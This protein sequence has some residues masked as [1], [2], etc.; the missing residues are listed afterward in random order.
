MPYKV[1]FTDVTIHP[2]PITVFD[3]T[4]STDTS[5]TFPGRNVTGYGQI[6]AENFLHLLENFASG[7]EPV[8]PVEGQLWYDSTNGTLMIWDNTAWK[9]ASNIQ[10]SPTEPSVQTSKIGELWVDTTNQ[11]LR[12]F[13]GTRWILVGPS[14]SSI[15]GLRYGPAVETIPDSDNISR[16]I[17]V[18]YLKDVPVVIIS[19][20]SFTPKVSISG[21]EFVKA[22]INIATPKDTT[23]KTTFATIFSGGY[24]PKLFGTAS[25]ADALNVVD[26]SGATTTVAAGKFLR[27]DIVNS[28]DYGFNVKNNNGIIIG[29]DGTFKLEASPTAAKIYNSSAGSSVDIQTN[30]NG[31][32]TTVLTVIDN[33]VGINKSSPD[34]EFDVDGN[35]GLNGSLIVSSTTESTNL[36][37][38]SIRTAGGIAVSKN[39]LVGSGIDVTGITQTNDVQPKLT[40]T[41]DSGT[42]LKRWKTVRAKT[43]EAD[44]IKGNLTGSIDGN[45]N[46]ANSLKTVT[47]F[48]LQ[49][50]V[51]S[52]TISFDGQVGSSAKVFATS[53]TA[54]IIKSKDEPFPN[55]SK[56]TD[57]I[58]TYRASEESGTSSGLLKQTR[59]TFIGDLGVP[60]G[61][62]LPYAGANAPYGY[63]LC[64]GSEVEKV[65]F[66]E[67]FDIIGTTYN[68]S[69]ALIGVG[70]YRLPDMRG[71]FALGRD[72]MDNGLTVP[73]VLNTYV[74][75]GGGT[76]SRVPD[77]NAQQLGKSAGGSS[78]SLT[79]TN[80]PDH[81]HS[82]QNSG[83]QYA[84]V[85]VDTAINPP[86]TTGLGPTAPGQ[87]QYLTT[88][89]PVKKPDPT[90]SLGTPVGIMNPYLTINYIIRSGPPAFTTTV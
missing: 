37:N 39:I 59:D 26:A 52:D 46:T 66:P 35:I 7:N 42:S 5:L 13:S 51:I 24:L 80:L 45:A 14:E 22:G 54:N 31:R 73:N 20:D 34:Y 29:V 89:G 33:K 63:L 48:K 79:L 49:G 56:K 81:E 71:R 47:T 3:N 90:F 36:N 69:A 87:A 1:N 15:D 40:D 85:R 23:E 57:Y 53:L 44:T 11:Q 8:N 72:N 67:L 43:I 77:T 76:A 84:A 68:G 25:D 65:K 28:T 27:S 64:D 86:A 82:L 83:T 60:I 58:L 6:I 18:L 2:D 50:D 55:T 74:D 41:Y 9:A 32:Q 4:S 16:S 61:T 75:A 30:R 10:K 19:K 38:G 62:I 21:F 12:I 78:V 70:T 17:L 88:S